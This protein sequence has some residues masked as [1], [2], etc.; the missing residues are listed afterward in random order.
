MEG[1]Y[2][3]DLIIAA[4]DSAAHVILPRWIIG[5]S[6]GFEPQLFATPDPSRGV[7]SR[8]Y[9]TLSRA[10]FGAHQKAPNFNWLP[11][12]FSTSQRKKRRCEPTLQPRQQTVSSVWLL[13][14]CRQRRRKSR[15]GQSNS[16]RANGPAE[17]WAAPTGPLLWNWGTAVRIHQP[18]A[19]T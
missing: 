11:V 16:P 3:F 5:G 19:P 18:P 9:L 8:L 1:E 15:R 12:V 6:A 4:S 10:C 13:S 17:K 2:R 14:F 7:K